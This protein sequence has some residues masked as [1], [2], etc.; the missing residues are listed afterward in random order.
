MKTD[1]KII[2]A[3]LNWGL[4]H[5]AR[6]IPII[7][8]LQN[9]GFTPIIASDGSALSLLK[10]EFP[11]L[12]TLK[13]PSYNIRYAKKGIFL[14]L[15]L[16]FQ[17]PKLLKAVFLEKKIISN[18]VAKNNVKGIISDNRF[19][20][21]AKNIPSVYITHQLQ[22][23]CG[24]FT[25]LASKLH[26]NIIKKFDDCWVPDFID[27][28][29]LSGA[30]GHLKKPSFP[31]H[32]LGVL[33]RFQKIKTTQK[34]DYLVLL[35]G[36][37]PQRS[38]LEYQLRLKFK[39]SKKQI[40]FILG[41]VEEEQVI[42]KSDT[43][44][45]YNYMTSKALSEAIQSSKIIIARSGYTTI[46]DLAKLDKKAFFIPT[47]GQSEQLYLAKRLEKLQIAPYVLQHKFEIMELD[48]IDDYSGLSSETNA[49]YASLF[50]IFSN[51]KENSEPRS[52]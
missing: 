4:G 43:I 22:I 28:A 35:T 49:E 50:S 31:I 5:A 42:T 36:P 39:N 2:V 19:G 33:S 3:P 17:I 30:L 46:M 48:R 12:Q 40:L 44:T 14:P 8:K 1:R 41:K 9:E 21:Y 29:N 10:K 13:L 45:F 24:W 34:Y 7:L 27:E 47:P 26:Q 32:Y 23:R 20:V 15:C 11:T 38:Q 37:E 25:F 18:F 16:I 6:C 52:T 51:V